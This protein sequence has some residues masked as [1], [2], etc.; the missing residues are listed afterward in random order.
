MESLSKTCLERC[1]LLTENTKKT[2]MDASPDG[3]IGEK[4]SCRPGVKERLVKERLVKG[5]RG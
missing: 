3:R 5:E 4:R 2:I 1:R